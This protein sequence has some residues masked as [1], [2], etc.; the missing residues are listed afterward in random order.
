MDIFAVVGRRSQV[1]NEPIRIAATTADDSDSEEQSEEEEP[2]G[3]S[4]PI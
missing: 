3:P 1:P 2:A 4:G